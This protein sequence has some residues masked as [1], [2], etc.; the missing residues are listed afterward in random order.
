ML[1]QANRTTARAIPETTEQPYQGPPHTQ[2]TR[3]QDNPTHTQSYPPPKKEP[4]PATTGHT[5]QQKAKTAIKPSNNI[6]PLQ[7]AAPKKEETQQQ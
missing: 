7:K 4:Y 1:Q 6:D 2:L 5:K 3:I